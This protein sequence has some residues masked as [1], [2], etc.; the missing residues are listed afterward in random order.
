MPPTDVRRVTLPPDHLII[1]TEHPDMNGQCR[2]DVEYKVAAQGKRSE[3]LSP[4]TYRA[5]INSTDRALLK[6]MRRARGERRWNSGNTNVSMLSQKQKDLRD[7]TSIN[8]CA[9]RFASYCP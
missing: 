9:L 8:C 1:E 5:A 2:I 6:A 3:I 7:P 4:P